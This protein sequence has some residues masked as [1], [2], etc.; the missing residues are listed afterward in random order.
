MWLQSTGALQRKLE[1]E[2]RL[3]GELE[4]DKERYDQRK[5]LEVQVCLLGIYLQQACLMPPHPLVHI[6][7]SGASAGFCQ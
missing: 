6:L 5:N 3:M 1:E 4:R 7:S 2:E